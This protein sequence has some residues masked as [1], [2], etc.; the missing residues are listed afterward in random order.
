MALTMT[1]LH[2]M[3][4]PGAQALGYELLAVEMVGS[5]A[6]ILRIYIDSPDGIDVE[7]CAKASRQFSAL[8]DVE[9][10]IANRYTLEVSSPG[11][12]RPLAKTEHFVNVIGS[13]IKVRLASANDGRRRY[14]GTL[15][16][17]EDDCVTLDVDGELIE[18]S[19][20]LMDKAR[21]VP[22]FSQLPAV[23]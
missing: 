22:D 18:L 12:D 1:A 15:V 6:K 19:I 8:L 20:A 10:P 13:R 21:L 14:T 5:D 11:L 9:D 7:D 3:L 4:E 2:Q 16:S 17:V 23:D